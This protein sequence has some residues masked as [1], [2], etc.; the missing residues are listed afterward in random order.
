ML[1]HRPLHDSNGLSH[2]CSQMLSC[3]VINV[4]LFEEQRMDLCSDFPCK[5]DSGVRK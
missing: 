4:F 3:I 2:L 1:S 5:Y